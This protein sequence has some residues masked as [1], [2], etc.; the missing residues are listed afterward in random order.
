MLPTLW[1]KKRRAVLVEQ[2]GGA[3]LEHGL[4]EAL[5]GLLP[6]VDL[7]DD[8]A[9]ADAER[10]AAHRCVGGQRHLGMTAPS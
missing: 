8:A 9:V 10:E 1:V 7:A 3:A 6:G 5:S 4:V 2:S